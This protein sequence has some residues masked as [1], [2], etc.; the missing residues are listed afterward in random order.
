MGNE[1][2]Q[3]N[4]TRYPAGFREQVM[5]VGATNRQR[6]SVPLTTYWNFAGASTG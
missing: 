2:A 4:G 1:F 3:D 6:V 5:A